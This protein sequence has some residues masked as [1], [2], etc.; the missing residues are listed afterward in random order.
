MQLLKDS[1]K[2]N[3]SNPANSA[4]FFCLRLLL[5]FCSNKIITFDKR[6]FVFMDYGCFFDLR[7]S[8]SMRIL[9]SVLMRE[10]AEIW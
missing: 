4:N 9:I 6:G 10:V 1:L 8:A 3:S 2:S 7:A 5:G